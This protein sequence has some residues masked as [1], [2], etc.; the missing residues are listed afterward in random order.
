MVEEDD[1]RT[2]R[3]DTDSHGNRWKPFRD[4]V[5]ESYTTTHSTWDLDAPPTALDFCQH[6][7][8]EYGDV[9]KWFFGVEPEQKNYRVFHET[10]VDIVYF[11]LC[12]THLK[13]GSLA[14]IELA[15]RRLQGCDLDVFQRIEC[16]LEHD[17]FDDT[18]G[19]GG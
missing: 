15:C 12:F 6:T 9:R 10:R 5:F 11:G 3:V 1:V 13:V 2:L 18:G 7:S 17:S 16:E 8:R 4:A 19:F 14:A